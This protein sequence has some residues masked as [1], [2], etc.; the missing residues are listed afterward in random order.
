MGKLICLPNSIESLKWG[1][2]KCI[3]YT[4]INFWEN[5]I[6]NKFNTVL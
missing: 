2:K 6:N 5:P 3:L 4:I 1:H